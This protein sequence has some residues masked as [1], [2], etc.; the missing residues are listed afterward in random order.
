M[1]R[2]RK[3]HVAEAFWGSNETL[4]RLAATNT[5]KEEQRQQCHLVFFFFIVV[6]VDDERGFCI[7]NEEEGEHDQK[8][9]SNANAWAFHGG[10]AHCSFFFSFFVLEFDVTV[11]SCLCGRTLS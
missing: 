9:A 5:N 3:E 8:S 2:T 7:W 6:V 4:S 1:Q 10:E 11:N